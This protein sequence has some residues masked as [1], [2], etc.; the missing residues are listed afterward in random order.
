ML[1]KENISSRW[2]I[3]IFNTCPR[4]SLLKDTNA[5]IEYKKENGVSNYTIT[6]IVVDDDSD[7]SDRPKKKKSRAS[8]GGDS[9]SE[10]SDNSWRE[11]KKRYR[12][13]ST[14]L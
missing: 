3:N 9:E 1:R 10:E 2:F 12:Y 5:D 7:D 13:Y 11:K 14:I 6:L 4:T 8:W